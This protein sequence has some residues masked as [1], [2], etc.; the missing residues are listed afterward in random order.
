M[1]NYLHYKNVELTPVLQEVVDSMKVMLSYISSTFVGGYTTINVTNTFKKY[2]TLVINDTDYLIYDVRPSWIKVKGDVT[3]YSKLESKGPY[4]MYGHMLEVATVLTERNK[5]N[6]FVF[7]NYPLVILPMDIE[8]EYD[9]IHDGV[10]FKDIKLFIVNITKPEYRVEDRKKMNYRPIL[11]PLYEKLIYNIRH[12]RNIIVDGI[13]PTHSK[14]DKYFWG[15]ELNGN[16]TATIL[17]DYLDAI[18]IKN[19]DLR[20]KD[21]TKC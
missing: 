2:E 6:K 15:S 4:F 17:N 13:F 9:A 14:K 18:E 21:T 20:V 19:L 3:A 16:N 11:Y 5:S 1:I 7:Q 8:S 12:N 10:L